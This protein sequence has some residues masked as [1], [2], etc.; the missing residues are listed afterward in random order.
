MALPRFH[1]SIASCRISGR[2]VRSVSD[3]ADY[4]MGDRRRLVMP[5][6]VSKPV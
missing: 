1:G 5:L 3:T 2:N 4:E 6:A